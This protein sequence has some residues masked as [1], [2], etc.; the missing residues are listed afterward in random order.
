[1][2]NAAAALLALAVTT[3]GQAEE[4][5]DLACKGLITSVSADGS[6]GALGAPGTPWSQTYRVHAATKEWC[7]G[8]CSDIEHVLIGQN[9]LWLKVIE[10]KDGQHADAGKVDSLRINRRNGELV[11]ISGEINQQGEWIGLRYIT[12]GHCS[13][14]PFKPFPHPLF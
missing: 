4:P 10:S 12:S 11:E 5:Y 9:V 1:M 8:S 2:I 3:S 6:D 13:K 7:A 14:E